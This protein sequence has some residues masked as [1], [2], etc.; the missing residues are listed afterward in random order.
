M[1]LKEFVRTAFIFVILITG[2]FASLIWFFSR[3]LYPVYIGTAILFVFLDILLIA[4]AIFSAVRFR[5]LFKTPIAPPK[6]AEKGTPKEAIRGQWEQIRALANSQTASEWNMAILRADALLDSILQDLGYEGE[7]FA[8]RLKTVDP[9]RLTSREDV[10]SAHRLRNMIAHEP[11]E[12]HPRDQVVYAL[13]AY[14]QALK[15]LDMME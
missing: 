4:W 10:W 13:R 11:S 1:N 8:A 3:D 15:E 5:V 14:E 7:D 2:F 9:T 12:Q 6:S